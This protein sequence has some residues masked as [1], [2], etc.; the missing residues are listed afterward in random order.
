MV[1]PVAK[2]NVLDFDFSSFLMCGL[3]LLCLLLDPIWDFLLYYYGFMGRLLLGAQPFFW[4][5]CMMREFK[6]LRLW[7]NGSGFA[8]GDGFV[9]YWVAWGQTTMSGLSGCPMLISFAQKWGE[10]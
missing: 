8:F 3:P 9:R 7:S 6:K 1:T 5:C 4:W 2:R 10:K